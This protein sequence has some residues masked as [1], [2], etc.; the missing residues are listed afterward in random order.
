MDRPEMNE[1]IE[2]IDETT[3]EEIKKEENS[4][5]QPAKK[6]KKKKKNRST[7]LI[8]CMML[9]GIGVMLY[10][11]ISNWYNELTGSYA[12]QEF[13]ETLAD[14]TE[15]ELT[16]QRAMAEAYNAT[17]RNEGT[18]SECPYAYNEIMD[19]GNG[20]MGY[21]DIPVIDVYLPIYH[22]V[23]EN[24]L[25]KGVGHM[26]RT[27]FPIGGEG[28]HSVLTGHTG[29]PAAYLF[30]DLD[31]MVEGD[32]FYLYVL[33]ETL[34]YEV[35]QILVVLPEE[36]DDILPEPGEDYCTLV[37]CTPYGVN[38]HRLLVRG[39]RVEYTAPVE[40]PEVVVEEG[41]S[42]GWIPA[43]CV[44]ALAVIAVSA[45]IYFAKKK[46]DKKQ[47]KNNKSKEM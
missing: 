4:A 21:I 31:E 18:V 16:E 10:P 15:Q 37:T 46:R 23:S 3:K 24:V 20:M 34:A 9:L 43:V 1:N 44:A 47:K 6:K 42:A 12:I 30:T 26:S 7:I 38:S 8:I 27:A 39:H 45:I 5:K 33:E 41:N 2:I 40:T 35:D 14:R 17:L 22:G 25:S 29:S 36:V 32:T 19:F 28:N 11:T 13:R